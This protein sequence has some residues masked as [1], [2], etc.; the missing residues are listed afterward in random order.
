MCSFSD[1]KRVSKGHYHHSYCGHFSPITVDLN[2]LLQAKLELREQLNHLSEWSFGR[3][4][5]LMSMFRLAHWQEWPN[6]ISDIVAARPPLIQPL[7]PIKNRDTSFSGLA[8][9]TGNDTIAPQSR[10]PSPVSL[11]TNASPPQIISTP[12]ASPGHD[13]PPKS[14]I[15]SSL[16]R[17]RG[18]FNKSKTKSQPEKS[19]GR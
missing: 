14:S 17:L 6:N 11:P 4:L 7:V 12:F 10:H 8:K 16:P 3:L 2:Q 13:S 1:A 19:A 9:T 5:R 18:F 15:P